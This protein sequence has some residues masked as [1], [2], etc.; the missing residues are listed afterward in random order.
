MRS[1]GKI[2]KYELSNVFRSRWIPA[3][4]LLLLLLTDALFRFGGGGERAV[5]SLLNVVLVFV[6]LV[7]LVF[8]TM[9]LYNAREFIELL[10]AQ[11]VGRAAIFT[12]LYGGL[13][14]PLAAAFAI[15][16][17]APFVYHRASATAAVAILLVTGVLLTAGFVAIA[18]CIAAWVQDRAKGL[19]LAILL[20]LLGTVVYD[21][22]VLLVVMVFG[23]YPLETPMLLLTLLNPID[24]GRVLMLLRLDIAALMGYTGAVFERF[25]G[26]PLGMVAA[27]AALLGWVALPLV[28]GLRRFRTRDF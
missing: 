6:P 10:L 18:F 8:G 19:G 26:G 12:G 11:P 14:L 13:T 23:D 2:L 20:W 15:G 9:Y 28:L 21:G 1:A 7:S 24:L 4:A 17:G 16:V 22:A 25:F 5:L 27:V 3:Y